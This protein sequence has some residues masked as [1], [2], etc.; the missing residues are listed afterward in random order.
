MNAKQKP[1]TL[2]AGFVS[3]GAAKP[4]DAT[5]PSEKFEPQNLSAPPTVIQPTVQ[6]S[7]RP[8]AE[9]AASQPTFN[10][11][12]SIEQMVK[13]SSNLGTKSLTVKVD[14]TTYVKLKEHGFKSGGKTNQDIFT[15]ALAMYFEAYKI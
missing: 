11:Q 10:Q 12:K 2:G 3:K 5:R 9:G 4:A 13:P 8:V 7:L 14:G 1:A 15:E 6:E